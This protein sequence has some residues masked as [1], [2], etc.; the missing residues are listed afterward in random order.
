MAVVP[1]TE[2]RG[3]N[4]MPPQRASG[5]KLGNAASAQKIPIS[6]TE[7][8]QKVTKISTLCAA[9]KNAGNAKSPVG[10]CT[11]S[12]WFSFFFDGTG[13][14]MEADL[15]NRKISN[16][17]KLY[18]VHMGDENI[19]WQKKETDD[20]S[21]N[22][23]RIYIP[24]VGTY[25]R[26]VGDP[27]VGY[28]NLL[29]GAIGYL[30]EERIAWAF[31]EFDKIMKSAIALA[32]N[33][34]NAITKINIAA[35]GFSRGAA[36][37]RAFIHDFVE[38]RCKL[39]DLDS[40]SWVIKE[41][42]YPVEIRF[43]GLFDTV[44]SVGSP[45]SNNNLDKGE[46]RKADYKINRRNRST[47][48]EH[49]MPA[50]IAFEP[51]GLPG[52]DPA[53]GW[54]NGHAGW[55]ARMM[56]PDMV[57]E[58]RHFVAAHETRNSFPLDSIQVLESRDKWR[59]RKNKFFEHVYP[60]VHSD[61]GGSY[62]PGEGGKNEVESTK[63]GLI[64]LLDM[65]K[66]ALTAD[67]PLLPKCAW[68]DLSSDFMMQD[69]VVKDYIAYKKCLRNS[70][71]FLG[72]MFIDHMRLYYEW[73]FY[74]IKQKRIFGDQSEAKRIA[75]GYANHEAERAKL[76]RDLDRKQLEMD[77][78]DKQII[79]LTNKQVMLGRKSTF[80]SAAQMAEYDSVT[81]DIKRSVIRKKI[82]LDEWSKI[83]AKMESIAKMEGLQRKVDDFDDHFMEDAEAIYA[84][85]DPKKLK[86]GLNVAFATL[87]PHYRAM[88]TAYYNEYKLVDSGLKDKRVITFFREYVHDSVAGF[89][90]DASFRSDPR[91]I[92]MGKNEKF[93]FAENDP[94]DSPIDLDG[95]VRTTTT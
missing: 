65:Y 21:C 77:S 22:V 18:R 58:V 15:K 71:T 78:E 38:N 9:I 87:R 3:E 25:F 63:L 92:Y 26:E 20:G 14:N 52:A 80:P 59:K 76:K 39:K 72:D 88:M 23:F 28:K 2:Q 69:Q 60:G 53:P 74:A 81:V 68:G 6:P 89:A 19:G 12:L 27:G 30:G 34:A 48:D 8:P 56:I 61:V 50:V 41:G 83:W 37:A 17:A 13:N 36:A 64:P 91:V 82:L 67:V 73:R 51:N 7:A 24:G 45:M 11:Q 54:S 5:A 84:K 32:T 42:D 31:G 70:A 93:K 35:F 75:N 44:A 79:D 10:S 85:I 62:M 95:K 66:H 16:V 29:G 1:K 90:K 49:T 86:L 46:A 40:D 55:G 47:D 57:K 43:M 33:P 4:A 94:Q